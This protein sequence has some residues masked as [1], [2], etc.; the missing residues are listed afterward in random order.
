MPANV[1]DQVLLQLKGAILD[2]MYHDGERLPPVTELAQ[3]F[4]VSPSSVRE[5]L[6][7]LEALGLVEM[8]HGRGVFVRSTKIHWQAKFNSFS[9]TV[10]QWGKVPG[11]VLLEGATLPAP[12][13]VAA[14]LNLS[15]AA[16]V[17]Y[18]RRLR[19]ADGEPLAIESS[20][21]PAERFPDLLRDYRD[22][23]SLY[24]MLMLQYGV[25]LG[26]GLQ[27]LEAIAT[28]AEDAGLLGIAPAAPALLMATIAYDHANAPVEYGLS[29]FRADRYRYVVRL[30]R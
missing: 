25:R 18:L 15:L 26:A 7:Q 8:I 27:T 24:Q 17:H 2:S 3:Q 19:T 14:Q 22:P 1:S 23:R 10:R 29:L 28:S 21:L 11:A 12:V 30:L 4:G 16:P 9:E 20:Y 13:D 5:A 6:K